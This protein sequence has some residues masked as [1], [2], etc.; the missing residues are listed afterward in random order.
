M[1]D[2]WKNRNGFKL[3]W[4]MKLVLVV[5][6]LL[7]FLGIGV[8]LGFFTGLEV[9]KTKADNQTLVTIVNVPNYNQTT[10]NKTIIP[11][12]TQPGENSSVNTTIKPPEAQNKEDETAGTSNE[13]VIINFKLTDESSQQFNYTFDELTRSTL[14]GNYSRTIIREYRKIPELYPLYEKFGRER[15]NK[16]N[17]SGFIQPV[18]HISMV[19]G[20]LDI[21]NYVALK[22]L[23]SV[24]PLAQYIKSKSRRD[25]DFVKNV[26]YLKS[27]IRH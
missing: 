16:F 4:K 14:E 1:A 7:V 5:V 27:H 18:I 21:D 23:D 8:M 26:L 24:R 2:T 22:D 17:Y 3:D 10:T 25:Y 6:A 15:V 20:S 11:P 9:A 19:E 12:I 13:I